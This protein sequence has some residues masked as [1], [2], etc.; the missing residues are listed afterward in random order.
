MGRGDVETWGHRGGDVGTWGL[1]CGDVGRT[2]LGT[3]DRGCGDMGMWGCRDV[4]CRH[5]DVGTLVCGTW[6]HGDVGCRARGR[7]DAGPGPQLAADP[8]GRG[9]GGCWA[10]RSGGCA[11]WT[12]PGSAACPA[13]P[14]PAWTALPNP[15][16][17]PPATTSGTAHATAW[18]HACHMR[19]R[20]LAR[21][22]SPRRHARY[23][24]WPDG[25]ERRTLT[26]AFGIRFDVLVYGNVRAALGAS[27]GTL[28]GPWGV[29]TPPPTGVSAP[30]GREVWH[31][32]HPHQHG[33]SFH[34]HRRGE[35]WPFSDPL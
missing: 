16:P 32:P 5:R 3:W 26:K 33:G 4:G 19:V 31:C 17:R 11:T 18:G 8:E 23:Y 1:G 12:V 14:S 21:P 20:S 22:D 15:L 2:G 30:P 24:R 9:R 10:S 28:W 13:T 35:L 29:G 6:G 25:T 27:P 7:G 34:L